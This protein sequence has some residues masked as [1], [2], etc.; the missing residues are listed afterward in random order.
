ME[1][2]HITTEQELQQAFFIRKEVF[3]EEQQVPVE[4]EIDQFDE[5]VHSCRHFLALT[6]DG[7]PVGA[8]R[9]R[10]YEPGTA[11]LQRIAV[12]KR[13]RGA[14]IGKLLVESMEKDA[15]KLGYQ[16]SILDAQ[17]SAEAF[18]RK[19]GYTTISTE[20]FLDAGIEHVRMSKNI[21]G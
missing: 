15:A 6:D 10:E 20:P 18:Y 12:L 17:C 1:C 9:W 16:R 7:A 8:S 19:L 14:G 4:E 21:T 13:Q 3:V 11:K 5:S 2:H